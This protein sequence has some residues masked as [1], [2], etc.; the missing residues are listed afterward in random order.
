[1]I[2]ENMEQYKDG[3]AVD[4][5]EVAT[6]IAYTDNAVVFADDAGDIFF[7]SADDPQAFELGTVCAV[8]ELQ[9]VSSASD[10]LQAEIDEAIKEE[11]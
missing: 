1:M 3:Q 11:A 4:E 8:A 10:T 2:K 7:L 9:P 5:K 6:A